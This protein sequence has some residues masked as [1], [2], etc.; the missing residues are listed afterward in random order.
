MKKSIKT[1]IAA[2]SAFCIAFGA[3]AGCGKKDKDIND[4]EI[5]VS[6]TEATEIESTDSVSEVTSDN[7]EA[8]ASEDEGVSYNIKYSGITDR[9]TIYTNKDTDYC[10]SEGKLYVVTDS[11]KVKLSDQENIASFNIIKDK[12]YYTVIDENHKAEFWDDSYYKCSCWKMDLDG[13]NPTKLTE[14][15]YPSHTVYSII[16]ASEDKLFISGEP[17]DEQLGFGDNLYKYDIKTDKQT[18]VTK[19]GDVLTSFTYVDGYIVFTGAHT[20]PKSME[21][22]CYDIKKD[23]VKNVNMY[24]NDIARLN[25]STV[26][27]S[28]SNGINSLDEKECSKGSGLFEYTPSTGKIKT[29]IENRKEE[30]KNEN[31]FIFIGSNNKDE[32]YFIINPNCISKYSSA[33]GLKKDFI[34]IDAGKYNTDNENSGVYSCSYNHTDNGY[35]VLYSVF[36]DSNARYLLLYPNSGNPKELYKTEEFIGDIG[37]NIM[38]I[39]VSDDNDDCKAVDIP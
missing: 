26:L 8:E 13:K 33:G 27:I 3:M 2:V 10:I 1:V 15:L 12:I 31:G 37:K 32:I 4:E 7:N 29:I 20:D 6:A 39:P 11:N 28:R 38:L 9:N 14:S 24:A 16:Y 5:T 23:S 30:M 19:K 22:F 17:T 21:V 18:N 35:Y 34:K 25:N 36:G